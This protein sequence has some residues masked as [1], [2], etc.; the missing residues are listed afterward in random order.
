[1]AWSCPVCDEE[2][3]GMAK[4]RHQ[5]NIYK[6]ANDVRRCDNS[7][8]NDTT[9]RRPIVDTSDDSDN[10]DMDFIAAPGS[11]QRIIHDDTA[12]T[13]ITTPV[14]QTPAFE[15]TRRP[16]VL[17]NVKERHYCLSNAIV[18][19]SMT[20]LNMVAIMD[21]WKM[22]VMSVHSK[23]SA[24]FWRF[25]LPLHAAS[26]STIDI[27]L[28]SAKKVFMQGAKG[29]QS[30]DQFP[31]TSR[32]LKHRIDERFWARITHTVRID[33]SGFKLAKPVKFI[34]FKF[35][36]PIFGWIIASQKQPP[37]SMH[38]KARPAY[39]QFGDRLYGGGIE[40]GH[41]FEEAC[42]SCPAGDHVFV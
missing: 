7:L 23:C 19:A 1:M 41:A 6:D 8:H 17:K 9:K 2:Y 31:G 16:R 14:P 28:A 5:R 36:D 11:A 24:D 29:T 26:K 20:P 10:C 27:A 39:N 25:F 37:E 4:A 30:W 3:V 18:P 38:F 40:Q 22:F 21:A 32:I 34:E 35:V 12:S 33:L 15:F 42:R 13:V